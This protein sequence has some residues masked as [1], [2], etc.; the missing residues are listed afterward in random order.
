LALAA[1]ALGFAADWAAPLGLLAQAPSE[2][3]Y[4]LGAA[5]VALALTIFAL[6]LRS[7]VRAGTPVQTRRSTTS[8]VTTGIYAHMR[9][10]I[11]VAFTLTLMGVAL[12]AAADWLI[13]ATLLFVLVVHFG[14]VRREEAYLEAR[15]GDAYRAYKARVPRY[16]WRF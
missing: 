3:R 11:Y 15:F 13:V 16:G 2:L 10:P 14:V 7:F 12:A 9:N 1:L 8:L 5:L 4:A 6:A